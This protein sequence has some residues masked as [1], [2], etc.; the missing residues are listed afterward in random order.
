MNIFSVLTR[1]VVLIFLVLPAMPARSAE[2]PSP[3]ADPAT[4][5][6]AAQIREHL[7]S[8]E[9]DLRRQL[10]S[11]VDRKSADN[12]AG[13][14]TPEEIQRLRHHLR[15]LEQ[16]IQAWQDVASDAERARL[17]AK[18][19]TLEPLVD[20]LERALKHPESVAGLSCRQRALR[21]DWPPGE[22]GVS[23]PGL[24]KGTVN[25]DCAD[26][27]AI[28]DGTFFGDLTDATPDGQGC[29]SGSPDVWL[30]YSSPVTMDVVA[31]TYGTG[32][33]TVLSVHTGCPGTY[34]NEL[35]CN[36]DFFGLQSAVGFRAQA[37]QQYLIR[38]ASLYSGE[39]GPFTLNVG[40]GGGISGTV[41]DEQTGEA[42]VSVRLEVR[43]ADGYSV[44]VAST[45][46]EGD[47]MAPGLPAGNY[48]IYT[49]NARGYLHEAYDDVP[50][51]R[52]FGCSSTDGTPITVVFG[53]VTGGIDLALN[54]GGLI[55]GTVTEATTGVPIDNATLRLWDTQGQSIGFGTDTSSSGRFAISGLWAGTYFVSVESSRYLD[56]LYD[57]IP[58]PAGCDPTTGMAIEV[59]FGAITDGVD[60]A[61]ERLGVISGSV[62]DSVT[63][64]PIASADVDVWDESGSRVAQGYADESG[65]Y[66]IG[67][68][69]PGS[70]FVTAED[71]DYLDEVFDDLPC[72]PDCDPTI[73]MLIPVSLN[74]TATDIDFALERLGV[75]T[76]TVTHEVTGVP[77]WGVDVYIYNDLGEIIRSDSTG[78][79]GSYFADRL[80]PG[81][82]TAVARS[83][84]YAQEL[85][86]EFPCRVDCDPTTGLPIAVSLNTMIDG[87][88]FT[89]DQKGQVS[90][91]VTHAVTGLP[92]HSVRVEIYDAGGNRVSSDD[93]NGAGEYIV[94]GLDP[95][96]HFAIAEE[97]GFVT[98]LYHGLPCVDGCDPTAGTPIAVSLNTVTGGIDFA[99]DQQG[100]ISGRVTHA[101]T[102]QPLRNVRI[103]VYDANGDRVSG[104]YTDSFGQYIAEG[105]NSGTYFA[106]AEDDWNY[107]SELY[108]GL[109][110]VDGCDP[111]AGAPINLALNTVVVGIDFT[112]DEKGQ[113]SGRVLHAGQPVSGAR[114]WIYNDSGQY[115]DV[116]FT[117]SDGRYV[118][119]RLDPGTHYAVA[120][121]DDFDN[122]L[123]DNL[124]C[125]GGCDP[126]AGTPIPVS[127]NST[128]QDIDFDLGY[129]TPT[130]TS[131]CLTGDR[132]RVEAIWKTFES[133]IGAAFAED[134]T[135]DAGTFWFFD[136]GNIELVVKVLDICDRP[137]NRFWVFAAGLT[138]V[139]VQ[140]RVIDE[141]T[142]ESVMYYNPLGLPYVP[143]LDTQAFATCDAGLRRAGSSSAVVEPEAVRPSSLPASGLKDECVPGSTNLCLGGGRFQAEA[144]WLAPNGDGGPA[145]VVPLTDETGYF[146]F[147]GPDNVEV[148][149]KVLDACAL[150]SHKFWV[151][152]AGLTNFEVT[153]TITDTVSDV[154]RVYT[155]DQGNNFEAITDTGAFDTCND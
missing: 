92:L 23:P 51:D 77:L 78:V 137:E 105:L 5:G 147:G 93:T 59:S 31:D 7:Q 38:V 109:P 127:V 65:S 153:L 79:S 113:I 86:Y 33:D 67:G 130:A 52:T 50:C 83:F 53:T 132:F 2:G 39:G 154:V 149:V 123:Y 89:L 48:V 58:C 4:S 36:D 100:Q 136:P 119:D 10:L 66:D 142:G 43:T 61:L 118:T 73:G 116:D 155:N 103:K 102:G 46:G 96:P 45:D 20:N 152:G 76:G 41:T 14:A 111:T 121:H 146:Y 69:A 63:G 32:F 125:E 40:P 81:T 19:R 134:L 106:V 47:Y 112:L 133:E 138:D 135:A 124:P 128:T 120:E 104:D 88:D 12:P 54:R 60:F 11:I 27:I 85:Y 49:E 95:G 55:S 13:V 129:C 44:G 97:F 141:L 84:E 24:V 6:A 34:E 107:V 26:A 82:Y 114:V 71:R 148:L 139:G 80:Y 117:D 70:Y 28:G 143:V 68:L 151:F 140:L 94:Q 21:L 37:G 56:E 98:E 1:L 115:E 90:G 144:T 30:A 99:L 35:A 57:D 91:R 3:V 62:L 122:E 8:T 108:N 42:V 150:P 126:T 64:F 131:L 110:C 145:H 9:R 29:Y 87:I 74:S 17:I 22:A 18:V 16:R 101:V 15:S 75:I 72:E 25:D